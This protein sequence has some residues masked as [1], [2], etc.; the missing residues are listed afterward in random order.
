MHSQRQLVKGLRAAALLATAGISSALVPCVLPA[1]QPRAARAPSGQPLPADSLTWLRPA[2]TLTWTGGAPDSRGD[3]AA[4]TGVGL[5]LALSAGAEG[6]LGPLHFRVAPE[7]FFSQNRDHQTLP[8]GDPARDPFASPFY[9]G[10]FSADLPSRPGDAA[11]ITVALGETGIWWAGDRAFVGVLASTPQW[12]PHSRGFGEG[13]VLGH[14]APGV[15]RLEAAFSW[16]PDVGPVRLRWFTGVVRESD[17][18]DD[19]SDNDSRILSGA[20]VEFAPHERLELGLARTAMSMSARGTLSAALHPFA[21]PGSDPVID[22]VSA[23]LSYAHDAAGT[24]AWLELARQEPFAGVR[25]FLRFP[26]RGIAFRAGLTQRIRRTAAAE[27]LAS[28]ELVRLDQSGAT[29]DA[30]PTDLYTSPTII[31]GWTHRGQ[32]LGSGVGPGGQRQVARLDRVGRTWHLGAFVE[33]IRRNEDAMYRQAPVVGEWHD[34]TVQAGFIVARRFGRC[35]VAARLSAGKRLNYLF[36]GAGS[37]AGSAPV[38]LSVLRFG[39]SFRPAGAA[40]RIV[41]VLPE[42]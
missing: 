10:Q 29:S 31:H 34:V 8:S 15:P 42:S 21:G 19:D 20:R 18:F 23:D 36:Q 22:I 40:R 38:D 25:D 4:L 17:W 2:L 7:F 16:R 28:M 12:G 6:A 39:L 1:Q 37:T 5:D 33:R 13:I 14:S 9:F 27:W 3:R 35:D 30:T 26:T 32:P 41:G 11:R 24:T